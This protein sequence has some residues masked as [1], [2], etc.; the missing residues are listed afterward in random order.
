[1]ASV[2]ILITGVFVVADVAAGALDP[3]EAL[4][5]HALAARTTRA[6]APAWTCLMLDLP[7]RA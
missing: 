7:R 2:A 4:E 6:S 3:D 1:V 5:P